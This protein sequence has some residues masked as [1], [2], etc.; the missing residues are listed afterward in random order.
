MSLL[1]DFVATLARAR[2]SY[3]D[4]QETVAAAY[5]DTG[6]KKTQ[7]YA[8]IMNVKEG[9]PTSDQRKSNGT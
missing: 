3:K 1:C 6:L 4:I 5:G 8:I 7:I 2:K 9:K